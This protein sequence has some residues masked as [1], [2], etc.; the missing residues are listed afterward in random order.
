M[1]AKEDA[2]LVCDCL[3]GDN[4]AFECLVRKYERP[5]YNLAYRMLKDRDDAEDITQTVFVKAYEKLDK[6]DPSHQFFSWIYRIAINES[7]NYA[8][9]ARRMDEYES[10]IS[11]SAT[12]TPED[13]YGDE[14][15]SEEIGDAIRQ[16]KL[17]YRMVLVLKHY[18]DFSYQ[19]IAE[20]LDIPDKTV[21]SRLFSARQ[22]LKDILT[23]RGIRG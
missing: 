16:L 10:G 19:E 9:K 14:S 3:G 11:G 6:F 12:S 21:K 5:I 17:D 23:A 13:V 20:I 15:L 7:I 2:T 18:H 8:K 22:Q 1:S 4:A